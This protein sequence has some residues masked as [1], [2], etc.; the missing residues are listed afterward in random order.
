MCYQLKWLQLWACEI[1]VTCFRSCSFLFFPAWLGVVSL[2][3]HPLTTL[4]WIPMIALSAALRFPPSTHFLKSRTTPG[5][6]TA[7]HPKEGESLAGRRPQ[8]GSE[9]NGAEEALSGVSIRPAASITSLPRTPLGIQVLVDS[10]VTFN[11]LFRNADALSSVTIDLSAGIC[12]ALFQ[13][14][15]C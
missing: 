14:G 6:T 8:R 7:A 4:Q 1:P 13:K 12:S 2:P 5:N 10:V 11:S 9:G 15:E 3:L